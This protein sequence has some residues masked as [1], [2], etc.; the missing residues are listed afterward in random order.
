M[1]VDKKILPIL[2]RYAAGDLSA[3]NA[4][5]DIQQLKIPGYDDPSA[6]EVILW[7]KAEGFGIPSPTKEEAEAEAQAFLNKLRH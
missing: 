1:P 5:Y 2:Q 7:S 4:A 6:S 3:V